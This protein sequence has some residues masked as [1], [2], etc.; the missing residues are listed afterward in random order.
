MNGEGARSYIMNGDKGISFTDSKD[1]PHFAPN[2]S[3]YLLP[4]DVVCLY[5]ENRKFFLH[6]E[7]YCAIATAIGEGGPSFRDLFRTLQRDFPADKI[8]EALTRLVNRRYVVSV[9]RNSKPSDFS[10]V[11]AGY[12][13]SLGLPPEIADSNL[14]S[15]A[16][17]YRFR[18]RRWRAGARRRP[19]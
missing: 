6:G 19:Q 16:C 7:L 13:A 15:N 1:I 3:V 9:S 14:R 17:A 8:Q 10:G 18:R 11:V 12:W 4:P 2:F 5:S